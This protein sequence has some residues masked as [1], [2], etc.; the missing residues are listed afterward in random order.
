MK[1]AIYFLIP[2]LFSQLSFAEDL[3]SRLMKARADKAVTEQASGYLQALNDDPATKALAEEVNKKR[4]EKYKEITAKT[5]G[6]NLETVEQAAGK[7]LV[8]KYNGK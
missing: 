2:F 3:E 1:A 8:E 7:L 5:E 4:R 6:A